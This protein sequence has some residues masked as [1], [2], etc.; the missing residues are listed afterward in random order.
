VTRKMPESNHIEYKLK[1]SDSLEK[2]VVAFLNYREGGV[3]YVGVDD[4]GQTAGLSDPD[5]DQL[6]IKERLKK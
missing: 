5:G 1:L 4:G 3:L 2:E 6:K